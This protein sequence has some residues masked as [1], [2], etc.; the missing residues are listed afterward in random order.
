MLTMFSKLLKQNY[1]EIGIMCNLA[2]PTVSES[3]ATV[4]NPNETVCLKFAVLRHW[5]KLKFFD[6]VDIHDNLWA[7]DSSAPMR[8]RRPTSLS[9]VNTG[10]G[11]VTGK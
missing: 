3:N 2:P 7:V 4:V 6:E 9:L 8:Q 5:H 10:R 11:H 1:A